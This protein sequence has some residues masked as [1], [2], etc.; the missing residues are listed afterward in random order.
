MAASDPVGHWRCSTLIFPFVWPRVQSRS[1][2]AEF[3][4]LEDKTG[5]IEA[6]PRKADDSTHDQE[7]GES[8]DKTGAI[9]AAPRKADICINQKKPTQK[10]TSAESHSAIN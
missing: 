3:G 10:K 8:E 5:A 1:E 4:G 9:E 6:A 2:D 7:H